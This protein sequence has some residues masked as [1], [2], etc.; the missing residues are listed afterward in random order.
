MFQT[1]YIFLKSLQRIDFIMK[2]ISYPKFIWNIFCISR[3]SSLDLM[4]EF[5]KPLVRHMKLLQNE[6]FHC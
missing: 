4:L 2:Y 6:T 5:R 3:E 1:T